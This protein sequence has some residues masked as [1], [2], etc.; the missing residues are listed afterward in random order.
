ML[1]MKKDRKGQN[2]NPNQDMSEEE[3]DGAVGVSSHI[4]TLST[5]SHT[6]RPGMKWKPGQETSGTEVQ[7]SR[8]SSSSVSRNLRTVLEMCGG[9]EKY[10]LLL[11]KGAHED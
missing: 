8:R 2:K 11:I 7:V 10:L 9:F 4:C 6:W 3:P 5:W 1:G